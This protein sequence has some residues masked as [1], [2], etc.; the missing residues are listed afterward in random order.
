MMRFLRA[1]FLLFAVFVLPL[2]AAEGDLWMTD[3]GAAKK[4]GAKEKKD[5]LLSFTGS[6]WRLT[7]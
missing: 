2:F 5:P 6:D 7:A 1:P 4:V 3:L